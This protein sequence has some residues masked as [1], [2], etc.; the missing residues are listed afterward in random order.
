MS[1]AYDGFAAL[2]AAAD[3]PPDVAIVD[4]GMPG[5]DGFELSERLRREHG[6]TMRLIAY[7]GWTDGTTRSRALESGF[8]T[9]VAKPAPFEVLVRALRG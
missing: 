5:M 9:V 8:E 7:T 2:A 3:A 4:L 6:A 1:V